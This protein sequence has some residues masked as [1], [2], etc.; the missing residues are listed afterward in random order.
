MEQSAA[1]A[2]LR[3]YIDNFSRLLRADTTTVPP[4]SRELERFYRLQA[5]LGEVF[6]HIIPL[7]EHEDFDG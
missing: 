3:T 1:D 2:R 5:L 4:D 7:C 6:P